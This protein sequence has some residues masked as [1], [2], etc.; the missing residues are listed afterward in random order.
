MVFEYVPRL[1]CS[2][3]NVRTLLHVDGQTIE[4]NRDKNPCRDTFP[5]TYPGLFR[6]YRHWEMEILCE[7]KPMEFCRFSL[8]ETTNTRPFINRWSSTKHRK[9]WTSSCQNH[10]LLYSTMLQACRRVPPPPPK[11][12]STI[13]SMQM[14]DQKAIL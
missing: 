13:R 5:H 3:T 8:S 14:N 12:C 11:S 1:P 10:C 7:N 4:Q 2:A 6:P 9:G